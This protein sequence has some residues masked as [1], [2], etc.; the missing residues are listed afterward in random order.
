MA[1]RFSHVIEIDYTKTFMPIVIKKL[2][3]IY[4]AIA[5]MLEL[6]I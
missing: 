6:I 5:T 1:Q 4:I 3:L 2:F